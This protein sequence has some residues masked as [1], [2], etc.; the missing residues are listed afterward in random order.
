[1]NKYARRMRILLVEDEA[2]LAD[3][4]A[5]ALRAEGLRPDVVGTLAAARERAHPSPTTCCCST[6]VCRTVT[7]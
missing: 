2:E 7:A 6:G 3:A 5:T 1:M 4:L